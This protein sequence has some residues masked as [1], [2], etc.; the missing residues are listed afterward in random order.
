MFVDG[1][2]NSKTALK[3]F[4]EQYSN[5]LKSK[6]K[7]E[8]K[9][10]ARCLSQQMSCVTS[11]EMEKMYCEYLNLMG[12]EHIVRKDVKIGEF[13]KKNNFKYIL[14]KIRVRSVA[15]V[16]CSNLEEFCADMPFTS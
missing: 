15:V 13:K 9:E 10:D 14:K 16:Q 3:Q 5:A 4:I 7:K 8:V 11:Y 2:I 1:Y 6:V 12:C